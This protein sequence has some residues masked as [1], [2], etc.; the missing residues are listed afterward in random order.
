MKLIRHDVREQR[1]LIPPSLNV[2]VARQL[3]GE[4]V[5]E[6]KMSAESVR[7][8][9]DGDARAAGGDRL[10][11]HEAIGEDHPLRRLHLDHLARGLGSVGIADEEGA[12]GARVDR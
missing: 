12:A 1:E 8:E 4:L 3:H 5:G 2:V 10:T 11:L 7:V 9:A 6:V